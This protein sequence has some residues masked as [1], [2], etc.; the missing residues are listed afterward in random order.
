[1]GLFS[2]PIKTFDDLFVH[3]LQDIYYAEKQ[4]AKNLPDMSEKATDPELK[5]AFQHHLTET[6][7]QIGRLEQVFKQHGQEVKGTT[8]AAM[9]GILDEA[10]EIMGDTDDP[11]VCDAAMLAAA[12]A[13]EHYEITRY[14]TLVAFAK[15]LGR[16]DCAGLLAANLDEE[17]ATDKKLTAIAESKVNRKAA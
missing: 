12:Q 11:E 13:V 3:M 10:S 16:E 14:G 4:I 9:D 1:M 17:K 8:C 2:K 5:A 6:Q 7:N 15:Q